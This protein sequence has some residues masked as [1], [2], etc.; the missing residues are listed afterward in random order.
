MSLN[1]A[2][3]TNQISLLGTEVSSY[4]YAHYNETLLGNNSIY[5][6][7]NPETWRYSHPLAIEKFKKRF[8][9]FFYNDISE[10][11][12]ILDNNKID[13]FYAQKAGRKDGV[14]SNKRKSV[15]HAVFQEH[16]LHGDRYA[17]ISEWLGKQYNM[18]YVPYIVELPNIDDDM[19]KELNISKDAIVFGRFGNNNTFDISFSYNAIRKILNERKDIYFLFMNTNKFYE[20]SNIIYLEGS[21]DPIIKTKF[22]NSC[23]AMIHG[24][25]RGE[26]FGMAIAEFSIRNKPIITYTICEDKAHLD[27]LGNNC[28]LYNNEN[29]LYNIFTNFKRIEKNWNM[30]S[31]FNPQ[32]VMKIFK[33][34]FID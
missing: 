16:E 7:K 1:I 2:F 10:I 21:S 28:Y 22:I 23:D 6:A 11:E 32:E 13:I 31:H 34:E 4:N 17:Y 27:I 20:H 18:P 24:R 15:I 5:L 14:V 19:R 8:P 26:S 30:Y 12:K 33:K 3:H 29:E 25:T 9:V